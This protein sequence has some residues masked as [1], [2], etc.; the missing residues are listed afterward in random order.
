MLLLLP[1]RRRVKCKWRTEDGRMAV[2]AVNRNFYEFPL[3]PQ[4]R[5]SG[6]AEVIFSADESKAT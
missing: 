1:P 6:A 3:R 5:R 4:Q 2:R